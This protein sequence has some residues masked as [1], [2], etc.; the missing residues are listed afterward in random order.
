M[1]ASSAAAPGSPRRIAILTGGG[2]CPGI[3]AV[4]RAVAKPA[5]LHHGIEVLGVEDGFEGLVQNRLRRLMEADVSGIL[6]VGGTILGSN[7]KCDPERY[8]DPQRDGEVRDA[9]DDCLHTIAEHRIDALVVIG[10]DGTHA[11]AHRLSK[12]CDVNIIGVPKTID[13]DL[14][15]ADL[16]FGFL[17]A[18]STATDA[19]DRVHTTGRSH[20]RVM[21]VE[22]MG[23]NAGWLALYSGIA[24]GADI[25]LMPEIPYDLGRIIASIQ[26]RRARGKRYTI[27]CVAEGARAA[28][29]SQVI[30]RLDPTS[31]DPVRLGG[32]AQ[33]L[34]NQIE[35]KTGMECRATVLG[36]VQRGGSPIAADRILAT[37]YGHHAM[38]LLVTGAR[39]RTVARQGG[40]ITDIALEAAASGQRLVPKDHPLIEAARDL[41]TGFGD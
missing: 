20:N 28:D 39:R 19:I 13:N 10:G 6:T 14:P 7:N 11:L 30:A 36:H 29:G 16:T 9:T 32:V 12:R 1:P 37:Q 5:I 35:D 2:D 22:V 27:V 17:T 34:A 31:P 15:G 26:A 18:V 4:I 40:V 38:R 21:L 3:N 25:I 23:R 8:H 41:G 33:T 24:S